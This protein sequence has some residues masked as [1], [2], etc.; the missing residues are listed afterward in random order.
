MELEIKVAKS[1]YRFLCRDEENIEIIEKLK[2]FG[3]TIFQG[4]KRSLR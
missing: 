3:F 4:E 2:G 1:V